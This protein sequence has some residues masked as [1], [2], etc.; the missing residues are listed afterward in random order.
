MIHF[1][2]AVAIAALVAAQDGRKFM[3][4]S[5]ERGPTWLDLVKAELQ[6]HQLGSSID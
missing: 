5:K 2:L 3:G 6:G 4:G 1:I